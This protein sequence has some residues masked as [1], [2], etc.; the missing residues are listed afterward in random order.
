M[1]RKLFGLILLLSLVLCVGCNKNKKDATPTP[2]PATPS[3]TPANLAKENLDKLPE[4]FD[5]M[6]SYQPQTAVDSS[7]GAGYDVT[8]QVSLGQQITELLGLSDLESISAEGTIDVKDTMAANL[9]FCINSDKFL[10]AHVFAD[11][12]NLL[13]NL[14]DYS[15]NYAAISWEELLS[16]VTEEDFLSGGDLTGSN[17]I[18]TISTVDNNSL[19]ANADLTKIIRDYVKDFAECFTHVSI[20]E[21]NTSI[22]TGDYLL[23]GKKHTVQANLNDV[24]AIMESLEAELQKY[25]ADFTFNMEELKAEDATTLF[26]DYYSSEDGAYAWAVYP[27]TNT[28]EPVV[29]INTALGFCLYKLYEDGT[30]EIAL[31]SEKT[32]PTSGTI[33]IPASEEDGEDVGTIDY[34][35]SD[36]SFT[37]QAMIDSVVF[38]LEL[39]KVNDTIRYEITVIAEGVSFVIKEIVAPTYVDVSC[40][41]AS[42]GMEY[43]TL[44]LSAKNRFYSEIPVPQNTVTMDDWSA[45]LDQEALLNDIM[46]QLQ[47]YPALAT[48]LFGTDEDSSW[49]DISDPSDEPLEIPEDYTNDFTTMTGYSVSDGYVDF[50]PVESEVLAIG[51]P[52][53]GFDTMPITENQ[54]SALFDYSKNAIPNCKT[55][56]DTFYWIWGSIEYQD[57]QSYY[58]EDH[59][60]TDSKNW[61][62]SLTFCFDAVSGEFASV[63]IYHED[64]DTAL[65]IANDILALLGVD[66][67]VTA[68]IVEDYTYAKNF[69]FS[70]YDGSEY[71]SNYYNVSFSVYYPEW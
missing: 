5:K 66:Y 15:E 33:T 18:S 42:Y 35:Y 70:G 59:S 44:S 53:T 40:S 45:A 14:P 2:V 61:D 29:F 65:A 60:F 51:Q 7:Q 25:S 34:E 12:A 57:V 48:L 3:P 43:L 17:V 55:S 47:K 16:S 4:L 49:D 11:S 50:Y 19:I 62:N 27:D 58:S 69:S 9:D 36:T 37:M 20:A 8:M 64:K 1:K 24:Y 30:T 56:T 23:A 67:T 32:T 39:S 10:N 38:T 13:F 41:M 28:N 6:M 63:D 31:Y 68:E 52:S 54:K 26:L 71:G 22:G 21:K 46:E